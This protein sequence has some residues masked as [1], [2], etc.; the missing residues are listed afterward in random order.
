MGREEF[1]DITLVRMGVIRYCANA[2]ADE[3]I[4]SCI[5]REVGNPPNRGIRI[6]IEKFLIDDIKYLQWEHTGARKVNQN[7]NW[8]LWQLTTN[9][10]PLNPHAAL[11]KPIW[12]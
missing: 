8:R 12:R 10:S 11:S 9:L 4:T 2:P 5:S 1:A 7:T 3:R 6:F